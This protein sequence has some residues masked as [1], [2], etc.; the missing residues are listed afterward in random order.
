MREARKHIVSIDDEAT[1]LALVQVILQDDYQ[2]TI[3]DDTQKALEVIPKIQPDLIICDVNMPSRDGF[4]IHSFFRTLPNLRSVPFIYLTGLSDRD[5][6]RKGMNLGADDY[7]TKPFTPEEL[8]EAVRTRLLRT[9]SLREDDWEITSLGGVEVTAKGK[10]LEYEAKKVIELLLYLMTK[11]G[12]VVWRELFSDLWGDVV[13]DNSVH[14][15]L[16]RARRAFEGLAEFV[17][18]GDTLNLS[19]SKPY[20]WDAQVFENEA[21]IA[22]EN[23]NPTQVEKAIQIYKGPFLKTFESPWSNT[24]RDYYEGLYVR[25]LEASIS[26]APTDALRQV[27]TK[28]LDNFWEST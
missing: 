10:I 11:S 14:V 26:V 28:R 3:F 27:A 20:V 13:N 5:H 25:L 8:K 4:E 17:I 9:H 24:Q 23:K 1:I 19:L 18:D 7:L 22:L 2:V 21:K 16:G 6:F 15:L 12:S